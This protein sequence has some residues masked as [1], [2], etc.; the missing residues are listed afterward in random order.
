[1]NK[2]RET[3]CY[4]VDMFDDLLSEKNIEIPCE[5]E[6]EQ[7]ERHHEDNTAAVYGMEYWN[8]VDKIEAML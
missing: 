8:L 6:Y 4:I 5:D 3:A 1:M 7:G 2:K